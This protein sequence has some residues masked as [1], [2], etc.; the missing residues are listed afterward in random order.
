MVEESESTSRSIFQN[1]WFVFAIALPLSL[2]FFPGET[3]IVP[4]TACHDFGAGILL[5]SPSNTGLRLLADS[6]PEKC[7]RVIFR[8]AEPTVLAMTLVIQ[9]IHQI[10]LR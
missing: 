4:G 10:Q 3:A 7:C 9:Q 5:L 6:L 8:K 2:P 1:C